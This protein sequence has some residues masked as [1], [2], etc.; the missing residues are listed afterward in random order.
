M[1]NT[2]LVISI[3]D[4]ALNSGWVLRKAD[5]TLVPFSRNRTSISGDH[6]RRKMAHVF[7]MR[8]KYVRLGQCNL[9]FFQILSTWTWS[10]LSVCFTTCSSST[11]TS[12]SVSDRAAFADP[13][14]FLIRS[15]LKSSANLF[16]DAFVDCALL[17][18]NY[19]CGF[20]PNRS[21]G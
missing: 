9:S 2:F 19:W 1:C 7:Q 11:N 10:R 18:A 8:E 20:L 5:G 3:T 14:N 15:Q 13:W 4:Q 21:S 17:R 6:R 12:T 16:L